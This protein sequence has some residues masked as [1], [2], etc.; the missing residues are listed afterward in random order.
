MSQG[1]LSP[2][3]A[4]KARVIFILLG[5]SFEDF[6]FDQA[7]EGYKNKDGGEVEDRCYLSNG[8]ERVFYWLASDSCECEKI[9]DENSEQDLTNGSE[10]HATLFRHM[11]EW[12][13]GQ[14]K[15]GQDQSQDSSEFI[16]NRAQDSVGKQK[17]S[18]WFDMGR[19]IK[20]VGRGV[21]VW[22][23]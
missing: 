9:C 17:V 8:D 12:D 1:E 16:W 18:F 5:P 10:Y 20:G 2:F 14:N 15:D 13:E 7:C 23:S 11:K 3:L 4:Y 19:G 21:V 6:V 22:V